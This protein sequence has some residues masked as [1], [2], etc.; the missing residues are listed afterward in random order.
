M[1][2]HVLLNAIGGIGQKAAESYEQN[3]RQTGEKRFHAV[4]EGRLLDRGS[5]IE[6]QRE[7]SAHHAGQQRYEQTLGQREILDCGLFLL[8]G[9]VLR[10]QRAGIADHGDTCQRDAHAYEQD[11]PLAP[12]QV[13]PGEDG[14]QQRAEAGTGTQRDRLA[15]R[16][17]QIAHAE[18]ERQTADAPEYTVN[19]RFE[20]SARAEQLEKPHALRHAQQRAQKREYEPCEN[21]L[22]DPEAFPSP[23]FHFLDGHIGAGLPEASYGDD[24]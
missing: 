21:T 19:D 22:N 3:D 20:R 8:F 15:E 4:G 2:L 13:R 14:R 11:Q 5:R 1:I 16:D 10:T 6:A 23:A 17:A 12:E 7:A 24:Q 9:H 18:S